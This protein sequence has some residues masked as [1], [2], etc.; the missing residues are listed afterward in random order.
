[1]IESVAEQIELSKSN[2]PFLVEIVTDDKWIAISLQINTFI[3][4]DL[5]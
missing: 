4:G 1:M 5:Y 2:G 3:L